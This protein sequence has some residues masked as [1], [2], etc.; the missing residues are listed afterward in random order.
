MKKIIGLLIVITFYTIAVAQTTVQKMEE[1]LGTYAK[2]EKFNG[3]VLV[4]RNGELLLDKGYGL[5]DMASSTVNT[6]QS[7]FQVGS[8]TKQFTS[9]VIMK[10]QEQGKL[11]VTDKL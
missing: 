10:L 9:T 4:A 8:V 5:Q 7:L 3:A 2:Q 1:L 11:K 6:P